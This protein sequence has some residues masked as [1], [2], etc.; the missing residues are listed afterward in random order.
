MH[1]ETRNDSLVVSY[2]FE[3]RLGNHGLRR[4]HLM[5]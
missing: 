3:F 5:N 4:G 2:R 1:P